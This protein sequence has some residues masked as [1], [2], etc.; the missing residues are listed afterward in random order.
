MNIATMD[1]ADCNFPPSRNL[2]VVILAAVLMLFV[3]AVSAFAAFNIGSHV[4]KVV[5]TT[6]A[7]ALASAYESCDEV[8]VISDDGATTN[9]NTAVIWIGGS[10]V[11]D[12]TAKGWPI[13]PGGVWSASM[14][15]FVT[16]PTKIYVISGTADQDV[17]WQC[18]NYR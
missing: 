12:N 18:I 2:R 16:D 17:F 4:K 5:P 15:G 13:R 6:T 9:G 11:D 1:W 10:D 3:A 8:M 14:A 7:T